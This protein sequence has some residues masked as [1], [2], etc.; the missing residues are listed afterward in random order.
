MPFKKGY[1]QLQKPLN[2]MYQGRHLINSH[3]RVNKG[4]LYVPGIGNMEA[5]VVD[6]DKDSNLRALY[7]EVLETHK[8]LRDGFD[9]T[10]I[11]GDAFNVIKREM[12]YNKEY[13][14]EIQQKYDGRKI[15]L[16]DFF[17]GRDKGS[18]CRH[19]GLGSAGIL[20]RM[21]DE[22]LLAGTARINWNSHP[23]LGGHAWGNI[24]HHAEKWVFWI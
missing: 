9:K 14:E 18:V 5:T 24:K 3:T 11:L 10:F 23:C 2:G 16:G 17:I 21:V 12:P 15:L 7:E 6:F 4:V 19:Q 22:E 13:V 8:K 1:T 20:E